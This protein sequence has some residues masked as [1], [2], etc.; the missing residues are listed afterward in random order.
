ML[1]GEGVATRSPSAPAVLPQET[2]L[3]RRVRRAIDWSDRQS[4]RLERRGLLLFVGL[5][6]LYWLVTG[7]LAAR[8]LMWNDELY[9]YY[10]A[11]LPSMRDV[12]GALLS[13]GEQ[14]PPFFY[15]TTRVAFDLFG[16]NDI[17]LRLPA[18][19]GFWLMSACLLVFVARRTSWLPALCAAAFP[20]VTMAYLYAFEA[21]AYG[22]VLG[23]AALA[24]VSWQSVALGRRRVLS[25]VCLAGSLSA[26][27]SSHYYGIFV[28]LPLALGETARSVSRRRVALAVWAAFAFPA[29]PLALHLPLIRAGQAYAGTFWAPPQWVNVPDFY[30]HLLSPTVVVLTVILVVAVVHAAV[31]RHDQAPFEGAPAP[32]PPASEIVAACGFILI[33]FVSVILAK[34]ATGAF[35]HRYAMPAVL[36]FA[37]LAGFGT[38]LAFRRHALMRAVTLACLVGWFALSQARELIEPT[39]FSLPV[40][41]LTVERPAEWLKAAPGA[42]LPFVVADPHT[43]AVLSH[44]GPPELRAR[45]VYLADPALALKHLGH[46][47]VERGMLDLL[48]P[49]FRMNV[50]EFE[51]FIADHPQFLVYGDFFRLGFLNW[52]TPELQHRGMRLEL[53]NR[54]GDNLFLLASRSG[55]VLD[56]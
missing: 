33:P 8:K 17:S 6:A 15:L 56:Q 26:A 7:V 29:V 39:G 18:M 22:L 31:L 45:M 54:Q 23:F 24:L 43:F 42:D 21:R 9:T 47:S 48:R 27:V 51:P 12:W 52:M 3:P 13:G 44:Y 32:A 36:G 5:S 34:L 38:A 19:F 35:T 55:R 41:R 37:V 50:V 28:I 40:S 2:R 1:H 11:V 4:E 53:L 14:T 46:N 49:W 20:T 30:S 10:V 16:V 25:L